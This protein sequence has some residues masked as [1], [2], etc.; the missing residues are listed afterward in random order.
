MRGCIPT[1]F[2]GIVPI[3]LSES[4]LI[5]D[6]RGPP[7]AFF[8]L[9]VPFARIAMFSMSVSFNLRPLGGLGILRRHNGTDSENL[10]VE[11]QKNAKTPGI[12]GVWRRGRSSAALSPDRR[13]GRAP[14][15]ASNSQTKPECRNS[16]QTNAKANPYTQV[17]VAGGPNVREQRVGGPPVANSG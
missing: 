3:S 1:Y 6:L 7:R 13:S 14:L 8:L 11:C 4:S 12:P 5:K 17:P 16:D 2:K 9:P 15:L 10:Q